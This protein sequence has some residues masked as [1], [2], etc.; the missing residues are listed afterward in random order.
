M[1]SNMVETR[2]LKK[3][4][5][6]GD[7]VV[8]ALDGV[9]FTVREQEFVAIIGRSGSGKSTLLHMVGGLDTPTEGDVYVAGRNLSGMTKEELAVFRRRKVGFIF[10][11]YNLVPDL[12]IYENVVLPIEL[13]GKRVDWEF[14]EEILDVLKL[15]EKGEAFPGNL[16]GGQ[17]QRAAIARALA[18]KPAIILADEPTGNLDTAS[19]HD[20]LGLLKAAAKQFQQTIVLITHDQDIAQMADRIVCI[21]DGKIRKERGLY[22]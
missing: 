2:G 1:E 6:L 4:Y 8:K 22:A 14:V 21:E 10:Q 20:V 12:N 3:Y 17:Q 11:N 15:T 5:R 7:N 19:G 16:S 9:D 18:S 13:D